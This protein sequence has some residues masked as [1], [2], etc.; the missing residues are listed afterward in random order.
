MAVN[1]ILTNDLITQGVEK[2]CYIKFYKP[3]AELQPY[4]RYYKRNK[5]QVLR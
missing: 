5:M 3:C 4:V 1:T 2:K